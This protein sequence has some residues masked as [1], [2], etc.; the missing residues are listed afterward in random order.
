LPCLIQVEA[1]V[2]FTVTFSAFRGGCTEHGGDE[3][4]VV[5][6][7]AV[8]SPYDFQ[9]RGGSTVCDDF[10]GGHRHIVQLRFDQPGNA[11]IVVGGRGTQN[12]PTAFQWTI[13]VR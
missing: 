5:G 13:V 3:V 12:M 6:R 9:R 4:T 1:G 8:V 2:A 10:V 7:R 11:L